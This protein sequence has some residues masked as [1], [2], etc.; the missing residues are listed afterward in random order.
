[1]PVNILNLREF[2]SLNTT[3][4]KFKEKKNFDK[5]VLV[6]GSVLIILLI[7]LYIL[8][9]PIQ[10]GENST[11]VKIGENIIT[12]E[13]SDTNKERSE[14]LSGRGSLPKDHGM[15]FVFEEAKKYPF[16]STRVSPKA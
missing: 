15:L 14:G 1:M 16:K 6:A 11:K 12:I 9:Q 8:N 5:F 10:F 13:V 4:S 7:S 3:I 2:K